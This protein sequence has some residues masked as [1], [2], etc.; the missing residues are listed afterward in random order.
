VVN[1]VYAREDIFYGPYAKDAPDLFLG[2]NIGYRSSWQT[3]IGGAPEELIEDNLK[4]W[5]GD[6]LFDPK[7]IPG[8]LFTNFK[9]DKENPSIYD[10]T[11]T[12]LKFCGYSDEELKGM[13]LDGSSLITQ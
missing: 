1:S 6:H 13:D 11:P 8:I 4:K 3:A 7:L 10:I 9:V 12:I 5:S 2:L